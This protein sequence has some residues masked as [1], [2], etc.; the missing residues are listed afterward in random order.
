MIVQ[1]DHLPHPVK[2]GSQPPKLDHRALR[3]AT[4]LAPDLPPAGPFDWTTKMA[5][6]AGVMLNDQLGDCVLP[7][8]E[9]NGCAI[10][11]AYRARYAGPVV[12]LITASGKRLSVTANHA[13]MTT[14]G[15]VRA[16]FL[17]KGDHVISSGSPESVLARVDDDFDQAPSRAEDLF[18]ALRSGSVLAPAKVR[19]PVDF[20]GDGAHFEGQVDVVNADRLLKAREIAALSKPEREFQ[21]GAGVGPAL[22]FHG[23]RSG[24]SGMKRVRG[25][26]PGLVSSGSAGAALLRREAVI[27]HQGVLGPSAQ[28]HASS[29]QPTGDGAATDP[30]LATKL[31]RGFPGLVAGDELV[32]VGHRVWSGHV[33]DFSSDAR[34]Y[35]ADGVIV[36]NCT[37]AAIGHIIQAWTAENG[38][39]VTLPDS[40][41]LKAYEDVGGYVTGK[42]ETDQGAVEMDVLSYFRTT[43]VGGYKADAFVALQPQNREHVLQAGKLFGP[44]YIGVA[45]PQTIR[46][47]GYRWFVDPTA[48]GGATPGSLGGHAVIVVK[49]DATGVWF[50]SWGELYFASWDW[51]LV[52]TVESYAVLSKTWAPA[53]ASPAGFNWA[54]LEADLAAVT[55]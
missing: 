10:G 35:Y 51:W 15:F 32:D 48:G 4:Y 19:G 14:R 53:G 23:Q 40:A 20:H 42:P 24:A 46:N 34:W 27:A 9:I 30:E 7:D 44:P 54:T 38:S 1:L 22:G 52:Y 6:P 29:A 45:L 31:R 47:Q 5:W 25:A 18:A 33:Y 26:A 16:R 8:T 11:R 21:F 2:L 12:D 28:W 55:G 3:M 41:I 49:A 17:Q 13:V 43:G 36:H 37:C 39:E 50:L